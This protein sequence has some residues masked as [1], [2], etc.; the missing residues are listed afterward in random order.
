MNAEELIIDADGHILEPPDLWETYIDPKYRDRAMRLRTGDD[1]YEC[2]EIDRKR[3]ALTTA[4]L[5]G[6][7]GGMKKLRALGP[8]LKEFNRRRR[9]KF[10]QAL[11]GGD[12]P[13]YDFGLTSGPQDTYSAGAGFGTMDMNERLELLNREGLAKAILY[14]TLGL[15]WGAELFDVELQGAYCRAYNRWI[16]EFC[17]DSGGRLIPIAHL[18]LG[19][20]AEAARELERAVKD[21]CKGAFFFAF[22]PNRKPHGHPDHARVFAAAQDLDVPLAIHPSMDKPEWSVWQRFDNIAWSDWFFETTGASATIQAL[23]TFFVYGVLERFPRL[24]LV[25]LESQAGWIGYWLDRADAAYLRTSV[26]GSVLL[27]EPPSFYFKR[28]CYISADPDERTI[29]GLTKMVGEDKFFWA[30]DYPH[31][32]HPSDYIEQLRGL[33][34]G[35]TPTARCG[36]LGENVARAYNL[37]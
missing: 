1:G 8:Q 12:I 16:A 36:I 30:T 18:S 22:T 25:V 3:S 2:L 5:L 29:A 27:E 34:E 23:A 31:P 11:H 6:A 20:P 17:R 26:G 4:P 35:M 24:K 21:G 32:D 15:V 13:L 37:I 33:V 7:L 28:Q 14:P 19:D 9:E 10:R